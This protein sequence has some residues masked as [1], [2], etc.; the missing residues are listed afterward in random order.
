MIATQNMSLNMRGVLEL[1][2]LWVAETL[3]EH[4]DF[5]YPQSQSQHEVSLRVILEP[6]Q[7][8]LEADQYALGLGGFPLEKDHCQVCLAF[9]DL[10]LDVATH[11][12]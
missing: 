4:R 9:H 10:C 11:L 7:R 8:T 2:G 6:C 1:G 3:R 5:S 12:A